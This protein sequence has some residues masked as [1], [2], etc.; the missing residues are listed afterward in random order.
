MC[1]IQFIMPMGRD[2]NRNDTELLAEYLLCGAKRN[3]DAWGISDGTKVFTKTGEFKEKDISCFKKFI[4][5]KYLFGHNRL[6]TQG[7]TI[8]PISY[9][10]WILAHN[11]ILS[12]YSVSYEKKKQEKD[13]DS[14]LFLKDFVSSNK[15]I[16]E[17]MEKVAGTYSIIMVNKETKE[18]FYLKNSSTNFRFAMLRHKTSGE[19][20]LVGSTDKDNIVDNIPSTYTYGFWVQSYDI[21]GMF[22][23][24]AHTIYKISKENGIELFD[25]YTYEY[26][27]KP[28]STT[29]MCLCKLTKSDS[30]S[31]EDKAVD[32]AIENSIETE[33]NDQFDGK[34]WKWKDQ[35][36]SE[37]YWSKFDNDKPWYYDAM[38]AQD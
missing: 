13:S 29:P 10:G 4:G 37:D 28:T 25:R 36:P 16:K 19:L 21:I 23:P 24:D 35:I 26:K 34:N 32:D 14:F 5:S 30:T 7:E 12:D 1:E 33:L 15:S 9:K 11:G 38:A 20:I 8:Q 18:I 2:I 17:F 27:C 3:N 6:A 22:E 31:I